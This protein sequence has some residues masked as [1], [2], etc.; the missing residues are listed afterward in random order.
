MTIIVAKSAPGRHIK[1]IGFSLV[2]AAFSLTAPA[3]A[4]TLTVTSSND[5]GP[6]TLRQ[7]IQTA[8]A[9]DTINFSITGLITL[10]NG[11]LL[12][13]NNLS[14]VGPGAT[15]LAISA[16]TNSR[17]FEIGSSVTGSISGLTLRDGYAGSGTNGGNLAPGGI[18][19]NGGGIYNAGNLTLAGCTLSENQAGSGG[20]GG[21]SGGSAEVGGNG[22]DGGGIY[23][24]GSLTLA[25]CTLSGNHAGSG[26]TGGT[27]GG[28]SNG[29]IGGN[30]GDGGAIYSTG[31]LA[32][33]SCTFSA[34]QA[35]TGGKG[36]L[37][38][39]FDGG[40]GGTGGDGGAI[41]STGALAATNSTFSSNTAG[42]G[43][44]G[45]AGI[46]ACVGPGG[47]GGNGG[48]IYSTNV[49]TLIACAFSGN[50]GGNGA[51][52]FSGCNFYVGGS[53]GSGGGIFNAATASSVALRNTLVGLN[54]VGVG[55]VGTHFGT[56][57]SPS[58]ANGIGPD[59][60]GTFTSQGH[61][62][63]GQTNGAIGFAD[64]V[65][66]DL[67]GSSA[68][69]LD[70]NLGPLQD[71]GGPTWTQA[72]LEGSPAQDAGDDALLAPPFNLL[73][74]QRGFARKI[75]PH[76]DIGPLESQ[77]VVTT[78]AATGVTASNATL[79]GT[80]NSGGAATTVYFHYGLTTNYGSLSASNSLAAGNT[81]VS[82]SNLL[83][84]LAPG[85]RYHFQLVGSNS[86]GVEFG[87]DLTFTTSAG[88]PT[89]TTLAASGVTTTNATLNGTLTTGGLNTSA[90][91]RY[92]LTTS[93]GSYSSTNALAA[94]NVPLSVSKL[95]GSL[96]GG[97][98]YHFQLVAS[99]S[100]G[101]SLGNDLTLT[102][103]NPPP[104]LTV[105]PT[106]I[107]F[108]LVI[109][110]QSS[111]QSF[112][113][114]NT[115]GSTL[116]GS[117]STA[118]PFAIGS[119]SPFS[120]AAGQT[121]LVQ[122]SFAPT[123]A[124]SF[125]NVVIFTS[126]GGNRTNTLTGSGLTPA[127]L[128]V[129]PASLNFGTVGVGSNVQA[130]FTVTNLG[131]A[132]L[133]NGTATVNGGPFT[134][135]SGTPFNLAGFGTTNLLVR[136]SP[137][138]AG[139]FSNVVIF[140][141]AN[142]GSSTNS[143]VGTGAV[144]P[145]ASFTGTPTGGPK[146]LTV[147]FIDTSTGTITNR[148][149]NFGDGS[150]TNAAATNVTH[151]YTATGTN[152]VVLTVSGP[153]GANNLT[154]TNYTIVTNPPPVLTVSPTNINFGPVIIGQSSTQSFQLINSGGS[155]LTGSASTTLP[156]AVGGG[157][158]FSVA[159]GQTGLV[160]VSFAPTNA[161]SFS[162]VVIFTSNA[163][164][165]TNVVV[166]SGLTPAQLSVIPASLNFGTVGVGSN[167]QASFTVTNLGGAALSN[168]TATVNG[169]PFTILSGT[170]FALAGFGSTNVV[171]RFNPTNSGT[172]SNVVTF[173]SAN[174]GSSTNPV[175]GTGAVVPTASFTGTPT[176]GAKPLIVNF[177][178][179][180]T[181]TIT[182]RFWD[183]GDGT[184][185][186]TAA[187]N[188]THTYTNAGTNSV[189]LTVSG[190]VGNST[191]IRTNYIVVTNLSPA[192]PVIDSAILL[193]NGAFQLTFTNANN[194]PF[195]VLGTTDLSFP[196]SNW[197][198]LGLS[199]NI[200]GGRHGFTDSEA[201]NFWNR[202]YLLRFP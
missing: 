173:N 62:L 99:N 149:W 118:L 185:T 163:G 180:S 39:S 91:F 58:G 161:A 66:A 65:N 152:T 86:F 5:S 79:N 75:G 122:V 20:K 55:G 98:T 197:S 155:T 27:F 139:A 200:G 17:I 61:N 199:T 101:T 12:I 187:T 175:V 51:G 4:A 35:G 37:D 21:P 110:G 183:F 3:P 174:A 67:A 178:D 192:P 29:G 34:N 151:T 195:S 71:N 38:A 45:G 129:I 146:P 126:N 96:T 134:I 119:G 15:N 68:A 124:A 16:N 63:V 190:P 103:S 156:F 85:T 72:L 47:D 164:N 109:I 113:L 116:T 196:V 46:G 59:L 23:N 1:S 186:N 32:V 83:V 22:G 7:V 150:T 153:V 43:G 201:S 170:P 69:P 189:T 60:A 141:S 194:Q 56:N 166:G 48:G 202:Y 50:S 31:V 40:P 94:T 125:S 93:Y 13:T 95:I 64:G 108:G 90:Y 84:G 102:T 168:G 136:F 159:A 9:G 131:G 44:A 53:G 78:L 100:A 30:G 28:N 18:G 54:S 97:T 87:G 26:G 76:V 143:V 42:P 52:N 162:N 160:Q 138:N 82:V 154:R 88:A 106:N 80:V 130:S 74:D 112:Q 6:G 10:T 70:P 8:A 120:I 144:V 188:L 176:A 128:S 89:V 184:Q 182:N 140:N 77:P 24:A 167:V 25:G 11:Q 123:N 132:A 135:L 111:T 114:I 181:G 142:A 117:A 179:T 137:T 147:A 193:A 49:L 145:T 107:N 171:V 115:G 73:T 172:F 165:R 198:V 177:T 36:G 127:Q 157:S 191:M 33:I 92:G 169:G 41:Y 81:T 121:G 19:T 104:L 57:S 14:I 148:F 2:L 133:S 105:S 158:P